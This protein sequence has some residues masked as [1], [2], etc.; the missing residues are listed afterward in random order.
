MLNP[1]F[2]IQ[3]GEVGQYAEELMRTAGLLA[4]PAGRIFCCQG[5]TVPH[6]TFPESFSAITASLTRRT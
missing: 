6:R 2:C 4:E 3:A 5:Q 1:C